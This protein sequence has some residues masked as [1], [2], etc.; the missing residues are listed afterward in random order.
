MLFVLNPIS[1]FLALPDFVRTATSSA[2]SWKKESSTSVSESA[3]F[4]GLGLPTLQSLGPEPASSGSNSI[5]PLSAGSAVRLSWMSEGR[6][7]ASACVAEGCVGASTSFA[8]DCGGGSGAV[9]AATFS[10][11]AWCCGAEAWCRASAPAA[12]SGAELAAAFDNEC[13]S[14][15]LPETI[16]SWTSVVFRSCSSP[17]R[18]LFMNI[19]FGTSPFSAVPVIKRVEERSSNFLRTASNVIPHFTSDCTR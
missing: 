8:D 4:P 16:P 18:A 1:L 15:T 12:G 13:L 7:A 17:S 10:G 6:T 5:V 19:T 3:A 9:L 14:S 2:V 11:G